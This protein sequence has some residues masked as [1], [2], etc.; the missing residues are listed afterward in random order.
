M[1]S[2][3]SLIEQ[4]KTL[5]EVFEYMEKYPQLKAKA[6]KRK[7]FKTNDF[8]KLFNQINNSKGISDIKRLIKECEE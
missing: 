8:K 2:Q 7:E 1:K 3:K 5:I 6:L 4:C